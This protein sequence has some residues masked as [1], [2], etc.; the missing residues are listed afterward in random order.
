[1]SIRCASS[2][3]RFSYTVVDPSMFQQSGGP[4][5]AELLWKAGVPDLRPADNRRVSQ[6][7]AMGGWDQVRARIKGDGERPM[8]FVF[9]TCRD[10]IRTLP[11]LQH[12]PDRPE[13]LDTASEDHAV[14]EITYACMS[15]PLTPKR[16]EVF[17]GQRDPIGRPIISIPRPKVL[18]EYTYDE[19]LATKKKERER[20]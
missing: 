13:D 14:D 20:V 9:S 10:T 5:L 11:A 15:R 8:L 2:G 18:S 7:G 19:F 3:E 6:R 16:K 4:S 17:D 12:D 1:M